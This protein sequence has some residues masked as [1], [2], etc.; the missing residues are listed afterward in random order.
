VKVSELKAL[1]KL[2]RDKIFDLLKRA[3]TKEALK[4]LEREFQER[5][6]FHDLYVDWVNE[7][8]ALLAEK[9]GDEAVFEFYNRYYKRRQVEMQDD[10][11]YL[12]PID[13]LV[14]YRAKRFS[15]GGHDFNFR[16][17]ED[18]EKFTF[19]LSPCGSGGR[20]IEK[21]VDLKYRTKISHPW[22]HLKSN[23]PYYCVHCFFIWELRSM[24]VVGYPRVVY[25][26]P[27]EAGDPC[28]QYMYKNPKDIPEIYFERIG[29]KKRPELLHPSP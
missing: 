22:S 11:K 27:E 18:E 2:N 26:I 21:S 4:L 28:I 20:L 19:I 1:T 24:E 9:A 8:I 7:L 3:K 29:M 13:E 12:L 25:R 14:R 15:G 10:D 17:V 23:I 5:Q 16:I 6:K